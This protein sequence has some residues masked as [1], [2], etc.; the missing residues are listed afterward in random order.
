[1]VKNPPAKPGDVRDTGSIPG[2]QRSPAGGNCNPLQYSCLGNS[3][4]RGAWRATV[5][6]CKE[7]AMTVFALGKT[8]YLS[9]GVLY[10][11]ICKSIIHLLYVYFYTYHIY[12]YLSSAL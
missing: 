10:I 8:I 11:S 9:L 1:M 3:T 5:Q 4:D 12:I 2:S 6:S 7:S